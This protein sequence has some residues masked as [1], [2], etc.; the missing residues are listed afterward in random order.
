M[1][2]GDEEKLDTDEMLDSEESQAEEALVEE[3]VDEA[4][5]LRWQL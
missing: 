3:L 2:G 5:R 4:E 1:F